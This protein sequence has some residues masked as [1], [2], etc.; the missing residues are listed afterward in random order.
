V[1]RDSSWWRSPARLWAAV[2]FALTA[3]GVAAWP[4][5]PH[6]GDLWYHLAS[7]RWIAGHHALPS[8]AFFSV[9]PAAAGWVDYYWLFQLLAFGTH[10]LGGYAA[11]VVLRGALL[12]AL[13]A[14]LLVHLRR[15]GSNTGGRFGG[16]Q[17]VLWTLVLLAVLPRFSSL[18]PHLFS[19]LLLAGFL[20]VLEHV[21]RALPALP[22]LAVLWANL[23]GIEYPV[24][25]LVLGAWAAPL[26]L[27]AVR[28][29]ALPAGE[30]RRR[31]VWLA[32]TALAPLV[33][34]H[35]LRL[36]PVPF[37]SVA[38]V[39]HAI[40]EMAPFDFDALPLRLTHGLSAE[41]AFILLLALAAAAL[42]DRAAK[43]SLLLPHLLLA[44]GG[45]VLL[46]RGTRFVMELVLL[47]VP[48]LAAWRPAALA[49]SPAL[50][51]LAAA[52][53]ALAAL[54]G[55]RDRLVTHRRWPL[56][57]AALPSGVS[58]FLERVGQGGAVLAYP[59]L[60]GWFEWT[61]DPRYRTF[62][63]LQAYLF[64]E[65]ALFLTGA[66]FADLNVL[67]AVV[68]RLQPAWIAAPTSAPHM[69]PRIDSVGGY[70]PVAFDWT[71]VL[72]ARRTGQETI[73]RGWALTAFDPYKPAARPRPPLLARAAYELARLHALD[74]RN[75]A[76]ATALS[77]ARLAQGNAREA[78][79]LATAATTLAPA[80]P[81]PWQLRGEALAASGRVR[82]A[83]DAYDTAE[84]RGA[85][86]AAVGRLRWAAW[87][88]LGEPA[89]AYRAFAPVV[90]PLG[91]D[92]SWT[93]LWGLA[94]SARGTGDLAAA[95]RLLS[96]ALWK[97]PPGPPR[98]RIAAAL[99]ELRREAGESQ[100][101]P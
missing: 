36:L 13:A 55:L 74:P 8:T 34:P 2:L 76:V 5:F 27:A 50:R 70:E 45:A 77:R 88:R 93:D 17:A 87:M 25:L 71:M 99:A 6:D 94:E 80:R 92:A 60:A 42:V 31:L 29:R 61:L 33:T 10:Q 79:R 1:I 51:R 56:D 62:A 7:G 98:E 81:E 73:V 53:F 44:A 32:L 11:L 57:E 100:P 85:A 64:D 91:G 101:R 58:R 89:R 47:L 67:S 90:S 20:L 23:H 24:L 69:Q 86:P 66:P 39:R 38:F 63:D 26:L 46:F 28:A 9:L 3:V 54:V 12:L 16:W 84:A 83:L 68:K 19:L 75:S 21:P 30:P 78:L 43:R 14:V 97:A 4:I 18:R 41:W 65:H 95:E 15:S 40:A 37:A 48:L 22:V 59:D 72:Y 49:A 35:G 52:A 82:A 96:F